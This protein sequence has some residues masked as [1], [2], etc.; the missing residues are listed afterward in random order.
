MRFIVAM[1][2]LVASVSTQCSQPFAAQL[3]ELEANHGGFTFPAEFDKHESIWLSWPTYENVTG[4]P[5]EA[6]QMEII[7][8]LEPY[9]K[10]DVIAQDDEEVAKIKELLAKSAVPT[11]HLR[12][13]TVTHN[14]IWIRDMG[15]LFLRNHKNKLKVVDFKFNTWGYETTDSENSKVEEAVD[16][17]IAKE[18]KLPTIR[19]NMVM[20]GGALEFNGKGTLITT[21]SVAF[22]RNP[23]M[24]KVE[25]ENEFKRLFG[26][27]KIIWMKRG[28]MEDDQT[29]KG[30]LPGDLY[31]VITTGGHA[32][33]FVRFVNHNTVLLAEASPHDRAHDPIAKVSGE[34][35]DENLKILRYAGDQDG[36]PLKIVRMP[37]P[38][39]I[40]ETLSPGDGVYEYIKG[41]NYED[42]SVFPHGEPVKAII[43]SSY[44][45]YVVTNG[46]VLAPAYW[47]PGRPE[48]TKQK[49]EEAV[50]ILQ[51][52]FPGRKIIQ[53][54]PEN[55]NTGGGGMHCITQ[56]QPAT[57]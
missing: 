10:V 30:K 39:P 12:F 18:L 48:T 53:I 7:R 57:L 32:D 1:S 5:S 14:D 27:K 49:D 31:T 34:R 51:S 15:P 44:L 47:K 54:N 17:L 42:G 16:R 38:D 26:V 45:N 52:V 40:I 13:H 11:H 43:A 21:E 9:V 2:L 29:F 55:I 20:E 36:R 41:L 35:M 25:M 24:T 37:M 22:Q 8:A 33:E 50:R 6:V 56:Q 19:S 4:R 3:S 23:N 28:L 46:V